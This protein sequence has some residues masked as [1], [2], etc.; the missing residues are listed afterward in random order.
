MVIYLNHELKNVAVRLS[1]GPD[2]SIIYHAVCDFYKND[3]D[4]RI[5]PYT[6]STPLRPHSGN[7][8]KQV[9]E[10]VSKLTGKL[11][12]EHYISWNE[13]HNPENDKVTNSR[14]YTKGQDDLED[15]LF[16][17]HQIDIR[18]AGLSINCPADGLIQSINKYNL[19]EKECLYSITTRD[20]S[21]DVATEET[22]IKSNGC[23]LCL[24]FARFDKREVYRTFEAY[25]VLDS[26]FPYTWSCEHND[27]IKDDDPVH[28]GKCYFCM[29]RIYAF[30]RL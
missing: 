10:I 26:L 3:P 24:P 8:A 14:E 22:L 21:R 15:E 7:K 23:L 1:G 11:P 9:V 19:N 16:R 5:Y 6:V 17:S 2:S 27:Q 29:E 12:E 20:M 28:C 30:G 4:A 25:G 18:Y 13:N